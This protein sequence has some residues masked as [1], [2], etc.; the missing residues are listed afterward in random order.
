MQKTE[1]NVVCVVYTG[2]KDTS[3]SQILQC[4]KERF[5]IELSPDTL[6]FAWLKGRW[7][8]EDT[9]WPRFTLLGQSVGS[10]LLSIEALQM[11]V[12][13]VFLGEFWICFFFF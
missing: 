8:V 11:I 9:T 7:L 6:A 2:D 5:D 10:M 12:P 4:V 13:D 3:K 1:P